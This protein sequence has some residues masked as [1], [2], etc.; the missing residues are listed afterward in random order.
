M[1]FLSRV[2]VTC[3][4]TYTEM[5][6]DMPTDSFDLSSLADLEQQQVYSLRLRL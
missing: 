2:D 4:L 3:H 5:D 6:V 1:D